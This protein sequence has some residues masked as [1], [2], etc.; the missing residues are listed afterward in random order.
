MTRQAPSLPVPGETVP[1]GLGRK[2]PRHR[3]IARR[4]CFAHDPLGP[5]RPP[6]P[7]R[8]PHPNTVTPVKPPCKSHSPLANL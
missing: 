4:L 6:M 1:I 2:L 7:S 3:K 8:A 5:I